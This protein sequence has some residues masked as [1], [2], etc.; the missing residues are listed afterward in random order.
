MTGLKPGKLR[1]RLYFWLMNLCLVLGPVGYLLWLTEPYG[2]DNAPAWYVALF[3]TTNIFL[4]YMSLFLM[5]AKFMR[6]DYAEGLW[7]RTLVVMAYCAAIVPPILFSG[8]W[9]LFAILGGDG[10]LLPDFYVAFEEAF[11]ESSFAPS[12]VVVRVWLTFMVSFVVIFQFLRWR[13][14]R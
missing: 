14:S 12:S 6:D 5:L 7:R 11:Y 10:T 8:P 9:I 2:P 3:L 1:Y 13:D 4:G